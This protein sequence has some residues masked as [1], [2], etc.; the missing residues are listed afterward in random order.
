[1]TGADFAT[2]FKTGGFKTGGF[3]TGGFTAGFAAFP[4]SFAA[5]LVLA[6]AALVLTADF[7]AIY[8]PLLRGD[9]CLA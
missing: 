9:E 1:L 5:A 6:G 8:S 4:W 3:K 2:D 7:A